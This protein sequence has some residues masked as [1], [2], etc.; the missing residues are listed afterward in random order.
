[1]KFAAW[2]SCREAYKWLTFRA[3]DTLEEAQAYRTPLGGP[4]RITSS[5]GREWITGQQA[6]F[7]GQPVGGPQWYGPFLVAELD[8]EDNRPADVSNPHPV[9]VDS[10]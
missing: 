6:G 5:D 7:D 9:E 4:N 8:P 1:M 2:N 3:F 10:Q